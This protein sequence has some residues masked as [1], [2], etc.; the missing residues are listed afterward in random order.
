MKKH[1]YTCTHTLPSPVQTVALSDTVGWLSAGLND[2]RHSPRISIS[3]GMLITAAI[4]AVV[5]GGSQFPILSLS[6]VGAFL[7]IS[8]LLAAGLYHTSRRREQGKNTQLER[9]MKAVRRNGWA[10]ASMGVILGLLTIVWG[11][12]AGII[13]ALSIPSLGYSNISSGL[14]SWNALLEPSPDGWLYLS[15][16]LMLGFAVSAFAIAVIALPMLYHRPVDPVTA[17]IKSLKTVREHLPIMLFWGLI[18]TLAVSAGIA[19]GYVALIVIM[20]VLAHAS[21]HCYRQL[22]DKRQHLSD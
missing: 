8:P 2:M 14:F 4:Y 11:R 12:I 9:A 5:Q 18:I 13:V 3:Y 20:P 7:V 10:L 16:P 1:H 17:M 19:A 15:L 22:A 21:W 6:F